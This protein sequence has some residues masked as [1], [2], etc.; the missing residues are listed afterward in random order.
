MNDIAERVARGAALLDQHK[1]DWWTKDNINLTNLDLMSGRCCI[2]GQ[3]FHQYDYGR[4][5]LGGISNDTATDYGFFHT[6]NLWVKKMP[7]SEE[8]AA[9]GA[10]WRDLIQRRRIGATPAPKVEE[11]AETKVPWVKAVVGVFTR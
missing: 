2:L 8:Y 9:L 10:A 1:P 4:M 3:L 5:Y 6:Q 7:M 11:P